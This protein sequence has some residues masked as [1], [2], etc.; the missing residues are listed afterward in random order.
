[1]MEEKGINSDFSKVSIQDNVS[2]SKTITSPFDDL[3]TNTRK[4]FNYSEF[5]SEG[6]VKFNYLIAF[7]K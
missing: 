2:G 5:L 7:L 3:H 4:D 1:M 6:F